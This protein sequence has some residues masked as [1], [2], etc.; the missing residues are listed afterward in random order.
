M[1]DEGEVPDEIGLA[2][3]RSRAY[4][5]SVAFGCNVARRCDEALPY[6]PP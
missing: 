1:T 4:G 6:L 5:D 2:W 3:I